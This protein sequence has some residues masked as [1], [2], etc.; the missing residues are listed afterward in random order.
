MGLYNAP[1]IVQTLMDTVFHD[2]IDNFLVVYFSD[3]LVFTHNKADHMRQ[4]EIVLSPLHAN[5]L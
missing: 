4:L 2:Y 1:V 3:P 5:Q